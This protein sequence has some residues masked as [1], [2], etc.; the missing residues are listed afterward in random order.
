MT[1]N[2]W[3]VGGAGDACVGTADT[4]VGRSACVGDIGDA[5]V[6]NIG[7]T[8]GVIVTAARYVFLYV[9]G[10]SA[11]MNGINRIVEWVGMVGRGVCQQSNRC[12]QIYI[13]N[14]LNSIDI[15]YI[16]GEGDREGEGEGIRR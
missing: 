4:C 1:I 6:G 7:G 16:W 11:G 5:C 9:R 2:V 8:G 15:W 3:K 14:Q 12:V 10:S 13:Q